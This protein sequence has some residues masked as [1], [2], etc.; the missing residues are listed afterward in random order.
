[1]AER[2]RAEQRAAVERAEREE[3]AARAERERAEQRAAVERAEREEAAA[4]AER[5][6]AERAAAERA[7]SEEEATRE[8]R[9]RAEVQA[10]VERV[11]RERAEQQAAVQRAEEEEATRRA[12]HER[13]LRTDAAQRSSDQRGSRRAAQWW[14]FQLLALGVAVAAWLAVA[15]LPDD[16]PTSPANRAS[17]TQ[18]TTTRPTEQPRVVQQGTLKPPR[19]SKSTGSGETAIVNYRKAEQFKLLI[20]AKNLR[21]AKEGAAYGV[22]LY[23]SS[24]Q[25]LFVGFPKA[26]VDARGKLEVVADLTPQTPSYKQVLLTLERVRAPTKPGSIVLSA[27]LALVRG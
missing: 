8:E 20:A 15:L 6:R 17:S 3:A 13:A 11:E 26:A 10:I 9:E 1:M 27:K 16:K 2:K 14:P 7:A 4:R 23:N 18:T 25:K 19:G 22:W 12:E 21:P 24:A 5:E